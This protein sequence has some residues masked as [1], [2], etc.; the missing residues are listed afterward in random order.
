[1]HLIEREELD[2]TSVA[3]AQVTD[4]YLA[5]LGILKEIQ[6]EFLTDFLVVA[7]KLLFIKSQALLPK[8]PAG[9]ADEED[10]DVG[11]QLAHQL[12]VYKQF[13]MSAQLL[14][15]WEEAGLR[16]FIR[17]APPPK[18]EPRLGLG[19]VTMDDLLTAVRQA[20][21]VR[22]AEPDVGEVISPITITIG[23]KMA[24]IQ[25]E[26]ARHGQISFR[27]LLR[28]A[29]SR[30]EIIVTFLGVLELIKQRKIEA[31]QEALFG[32]ILISALTHGSSNPNIPHA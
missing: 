25:R 30:L 21:A 1:L 18:L 28:R 23:Q 26:M 29:S 12:R 24:L 20:L 7:A 4:Q 31:R 10:E 11:D 15:Q 17:L 13:K 32:D 19:E 14:R 22:S 3:L 8:P 2:I 16:S 27:N 5:Y 6:V 9:L